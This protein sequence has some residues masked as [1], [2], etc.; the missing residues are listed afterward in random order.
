MRRLQA[1]ILKEFIFQQQQN[2]DR[3]HRTYVYV[4]TVTE[5]L[6]AWEDSVNIGEFVCVCVLLLL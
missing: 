3:K 2:Q 6:D 5:T 4:L 1:L